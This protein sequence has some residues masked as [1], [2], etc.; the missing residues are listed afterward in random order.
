[1]KRVQQIFAL[2]ILTILF[3]V[4]ATT[5]SIGQNRLPEIN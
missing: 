1:M 4:I 3:V 5:Y 2:V